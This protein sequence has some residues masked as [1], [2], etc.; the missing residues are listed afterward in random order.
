MAHVND[1]MANAEIEAYKEQL[2]QIIANKVVLAIRRDVNL[3]A[4]RQS[5]DQQ[6]VLAAV[7]ELIRVTNEHRDIVHQLYQTIRSLRRQVTS[8]AA[9]TASTPYDPAQPTRMVWDEFPE[10]T[11]RPERPQRPHRPGP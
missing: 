8:I 4:D 2:A 9:A 1:A 6:L 5:D 3:I 7:D 10:R 11:E